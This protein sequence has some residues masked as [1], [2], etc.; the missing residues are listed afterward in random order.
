MVREAN[1]RGRHV[2]EKMGF[3]RFDPAPELAKRYDEF[4][5]APGDGVF[6]MRIEKTR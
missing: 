4:E 3:A 6:R 1:A 5:E 2:Y